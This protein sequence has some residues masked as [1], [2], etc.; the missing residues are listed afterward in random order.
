MGGPAAGDEGYE[1]DDEWEQD[2]DLG[3]KIG[4]KVKSKSSS[5][6]SST[7]APPSFRARLQQQQRLKQKQ[8]Q[9]QQ[10]ITHTYTL[11]RFSTGQV[12][13]E[14]FQI[15]WYDIQPHE[16][17]ELHS[18]FSPP[19][20]A[21]SL[22][23]PMS[24]SPT[25]DGAM[26]LSQN[27]SAQ[28]KKKKKKSSSANTT[29]Q[30]DP[31][32]PSVAALSRH[33]PNLYIQPYWQGWVRALRVLWRTQT[34][35]ENDEHPNP[36]DTL[37]RGWE[38]RGEGREGRDWRHGEKAEWREKWVVIHDGVVNIC[39]NPN[40]GDL[41]IFNLKLTVH[42]FI[43]SRIQIQLVS[44]SRPSWLSAVQNS[45]LIPYIPQTAPAN[46]LCEVSHA[47]QNLQQRRQRQQE[48]CAH[49][50]CTFRH[51][52]TFPNRSEITKRQRKTSPTKTLSGKRV[53]SRNP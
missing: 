2:F 5:P 20:F 7:T 13:E 38:E 46:L 36:S 29:D 4:V 34:V 52:K 39:R 10:I 45:L 53:I 28:K 41:F 21:S 15:S 42:Y 48:L 44:L 17:V 23:S 25:V 50:A 9:E 3:R 49:V 11:F 30:G 26:V 37:K 14:D 40:V 6:S 51:Q 18:S 19:T 32:I 1:E 43:F 47:H 27:T 24:I 33:Q 35:P 22:L 16:L 12:L 31:A 8:E